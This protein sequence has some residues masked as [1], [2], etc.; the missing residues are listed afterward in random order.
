[1]TRFNFLVPFVH[2]PQ[3]IW[4]SLAR[5]NDL[6]ATLLCNPK[7]FK[8]EEFLRYLPISGININ[9]QRAVIR[10]SDCTMNYWTVGPSILPASVHHPTIQPFVDQTT[11]TGTSPHEDGPTKVHIQKLHIRHEVLK[12]TRM[13]MRLFTPT[14]FLTIPKVLVPI[15]FTKPRGK[16]R[17]QNLWEPAPK[18]PFLALYELPYTHEAWHQSAL[19]LS[20]TLEWIKFFDK[21]K[22]VTWTG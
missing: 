7:W 15:Y 2:P 20:Q 10:T 3:S 6:F 4:T 13:R 16:A 9:N 19:V 11:I 14:W 22:I 18:H 12:E 8:S 5:F 17:L 21:K 1:M